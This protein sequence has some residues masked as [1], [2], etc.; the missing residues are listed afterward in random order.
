MRALA[1]AAITIAIIMIIPSCGGPLYDGSIPHLDD[2][3]NRD[4]ANALAGWEDSSSGTGAPR[5]VDFNGMKVA[6]GTSVIDST[7]PGYIGID[8]PLGWSSEQLE[9]QLDHLSMWVDD[10]LV[11]PNLDANH[12]EILFPI[13]GYP[14][15]NGDP[16]FVPDGWTFVKN[17]ALPSGTQHPQHGYF[18]LNGRS[19]EGYDGS[20]GW[21]FDANYGSSTTFDP[22]MGI[23]MSQQVPT[24]W[25]EI[26]S[27]EIT[28]L[29]Y[30][31]SIS[32]LNDEVFIFTRLEDFVS[33]HHVF[34]TGIAMDTWLQ[35]TAIVPTS[36]LQSLEI[37]DALL[38]DIGLG[39]DM[40][41]LPAGSSDHEVYIDEIEMKLLVRP[42]PE[43]IDLRAN[44]ARVTGSTQGS[45]SPYVPDGSNRDCY[46][47]PNSNGGSGGVDLDGYAYPPSYQGYLDVGAD[48]P[49]YPIWDTAY[50]YQVG[51]QFPIHIPQGSTITTAT[52]QVETPSDSTGFPGMRIY[53]AN[54][55]TVSAFSSGY[56][57]LPD[58]YDWVNTSIY[59]RPSTWL[60]N[61]RYDTPDLSALIQ[62][63]VA[64]PGWQ[65][66]NYICIMIDYAYSNQQ[67][68]Y[69]TI[70]G[71]AGFPQGQLSRLY[72]DFTASDPSDVIPSFRYN[73]NI[74]I[75]HTRV[76]S[77]LQNFPVLVDIWDADLH[78][79]VQPDGD[80]IA[81]LYNGQ[82]IPH[83]IDVFDKLGNGTHAHLSAWVNVPYVSSVQDTTIVM[84]YGDDNLGNQ[85]NTE[86]VWDSDFSAVWHLRENPAQPQWSSTYADY[87]P[88]Q[89]QILDV[90]SL[91]NDGISSGSMTSNDLVGG[92]IGDAIDLE[93]TDDY[94]DFANPTDLQMNGAFT[95]E[96]WFYADFVD[97]DYLVVKSGESNF[98]GWDLSFDDDP[99]ISPAGWVMFRW[100][101]DGVAM[102][103]VGYHRVDIGQWYHVVGV[104][105]P[106]EYTRFY[107]NGEL[108][109]E[110]T[111]G[112]P[113][114]VNDPNRPLRI[115]RRSDGAG[116]TSYFDGIVDEVRL[117]S[118]ARSD[119]WI[120]TQYNNQR[121]PELFMSVGEEG[122]NFR[123]MKD[124]IIDHNKVP[125]DLTR[126]PVLIDIFDTDLRTDVQADGDDIMFTSNGR[127]L[128]HEI[129]LFDQQFNS[130]HGHL[131]AWVKADLSSASDTVLTMYYGNPS[132]GSQEDPTGVWSNK[133]Y[134]VWHLGET[135][136][137]AL[138]STFLGIDGTLM[139]G[140]TRG[141]PGT[142]G[143]AYEFDGG[144]D[145]LA[146]ANAYTEVTGTYSFWLYPHS[147]TDEIN[148]MASEPWLNRIA[149]Y[150][151]RFRPETAI[152]S[153]YFD[154]TS[155]SIA[156]ND[157]QH[158]VFVRAGDFGD[159]YID[160]AW[161]E[162][163]EVVGATTLTVDSIGGTDDIV[164]MFDGI[165]DEPR[166]STTPRS[167]DWVITEYNNQYDPSSFYSLGSE[168]E[169]LAPN[170]GPVGF[171]YK[172]YIT[173]DH[174]KVDTDLSGFPVLIDLYDTDL[175]TDVQADGDDIV[176]VRDG[177]I[178]PHEIELFVQSYNPYR[179]LSYHY[180]TV[181]QH[182]EIKRILQVYGT[183]H[184]VRYGISAKIQLAPSS[185]VP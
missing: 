123:Y 158:I 75:E 24:P 15:Y 159:L 153:E 48:V 141:I 2:F 60:A 51:L 168:R 23:Y 6:S 116:A 87:L 162:Q 14:E 138:D 81:F 36:Y 167:A 127:S 154:F 175:R 104:F 163:V 128:P 161:V 56:P 134:G 97:N 32:V 151:G 66:G 164:R 152:D 147:V 4:A 179:T 145:Y 173:I 122:V 83:E 121:N 107:V 135:T 144:D 93:G 117:S 77:D 119:A 52:L 49:A 143:Y 71:S 67:Y 70:K 109:G 86:N 184:S 26:Y 28:F 53:V 19:G 88:H 61:G 177:W 98:R 111:S 45:I 174:N 105:S 132:I 130:T 182:Q 11:N 64:R 17:D 146:L 76:A 180:T 139:G 99:S 100:S 136:G 176:F 150:N 183:H 30:V 114:T 25:R 7:H 160:G 118:I 166:I 169:V 44:G 112:I 79:D 103:T 16:F 21:R 126:F 39:T 54:E 12:E 3:E 38:F 85:E 113:A 47:A 82:V 72:V 62:E 20:I 157:W 40:S 80:D 170:E 5:A 18:E 131:I 43:Q 9:G 10:V 68:A 108:V 106:S 29:Y 57:L 148:F 55:D 58:R 185:I 140:P 172:K 27:A 65:S 22:S 41:G 69:N 137:D 46:S 8:P 149:I 125:S 94:I 31:S 95:V 133:F 110:V 78:L 178:L 90:T 74:I 92:F 171:V 42:Y 50:A 13:A 37:H 156:I 59:W 96:A 1:A 84:V 89:P 35:A 33:K 73:K 142:I 34:E 120:M 102:D 124:I 129:E 155:S 101:P 63:V 115:G 165:I 181:T 91:G